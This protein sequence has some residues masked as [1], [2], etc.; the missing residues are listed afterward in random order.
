MKR[1][2]GIK[3]S[4]GV[5]SVMALCKCM[6]KVYVGGGAKLLFSSVPVVLMASCFESFG[7]CF[8]KYISSVFSSGLKILPLAMSSLNDRSI[9]A[10]QATHY[11]QGC[12]FSAPQNL[13]LSLQGPGSN[14]LRS[15][16]QLQFRVFPHSEKPGPRTQCSS[17]SQVS[18]ASRVT[19]VLAPQDD[20]GG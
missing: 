3:K 9:V 7:Y 20:L 10:I 1:L 6:V 18:T 12:A 2:L 15:M 4:H 14:S 5:K 16:T 8:Q 17:E 11:E 13:Q 19:M